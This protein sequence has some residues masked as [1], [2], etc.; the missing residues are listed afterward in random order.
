M[1]KVD[2]VLLVVL[3]TILS[4]SCNSK[5]VK[6]NDSSDAEQHM[7]TPEEVEQQLATV[8]EAETILNEMEKSYWSIN[9]TKIKSTFE[10]KG[11]KYF[12]DSELVGR[13]YCL[14]NCKAQKDIED[15]SY[16]CSVVNSDSLAS[17]ICFVAQGDINDES[18]PYGYNLIYNKLYGILS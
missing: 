18:M 10:T 4:M 12:V 6:S 2:Y 1:K 3:I 17:A 13:Y 7:V 8:A 5:S 9:E 15:Y 11:Y 14:K 16:S